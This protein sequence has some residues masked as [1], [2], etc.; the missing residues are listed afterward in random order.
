MDIQAEK[1]N[2]L[3]AIMN[4][5]DEGLLM[6]VKAFLTDQ[7]SDWF[8]RLDEDQQKDILEGLKQADEGQTKSHAEVV[9]RFGKWGLK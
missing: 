2:L 7:K 9:Q 3:Q 4:I 8:E 5:N 1:L 6:D